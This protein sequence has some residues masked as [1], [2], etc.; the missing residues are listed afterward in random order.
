MMNRLESMKMTAVRWYYDPLITVQ[1][2]N[3]ESVEDIKVGPGMTVPLPPDTK[4]EQVIATP[5]HQLIQFAMESLEKSVQEGTYPGVM[6]GQSPGSLQAGYGVSILS[7]AAEGRSTQT[8]YN[9]E[10]TIERCNQLVLNLAETFSGKDGIQV[11]GKEPG[12]SG[13]YYETLKAEDID[14]YYENHVTLK[15]NIP[16]NDVQDVTM[17]LRLRQDGIV[18]TEWVRDNLPYP[19]PPDEKHRV[20]IDQMG[21][22]PEVQRM[23]FLAALQKTRPDDWQQFASEAGLIEPPAP[24]QPMLPPA[25]PPMPP[26]MMGMP[27]QGM[28]PGMPMQPP[29]MNM[30]AG[31]F[32]PNQIGQFTPEMMGLPPDIDPMMWAMMMNQPIPP[33]QELQMMGGM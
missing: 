1:N 9:V 17:M 11:Y 27:P 21:Q 15:H 5:N 6:F 32:P 26:E 16:Q 19:M 20:L 13:F 24:E 25:Q 29:S 14:G 31:T 3:G 23:L 8:R 33:E 7:N 22:T 10:R 28:P 12:K 2:M 30:D 4:I 18:S